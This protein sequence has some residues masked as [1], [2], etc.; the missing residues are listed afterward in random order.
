MELSWC[1]IRLFI[2]SW[3]FTVLIEGNF[4]YSKY[5][6]TLEEKSSP[7]RESSIAGGSMGFDF[8][9]FQPKGKVKYG[10]DVYSFLTKFK[11]YNSAVTT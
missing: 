5:H 7:L 1:W 11:T 8:T 4:S 2:N 3:K 10:F 9:S 6:I